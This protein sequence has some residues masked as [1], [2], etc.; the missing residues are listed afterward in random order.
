MILRE[1]CV[2]AAAGLMVGVPVILATSRLVESFL[3]DMTPADPAALAGAVAMLLAAAL[4]AGYVPAR[5]ASR[6][7]PMIALRQE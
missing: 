3:F 4:I 7:V 1:V 6:V 2:M 5:H